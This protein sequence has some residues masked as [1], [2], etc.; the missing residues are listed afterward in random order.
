M[1]LEVGRIIEVRYAGARVCL[2]DGSR[3]CLG[4]RTCK[5]IRSPIAGNIVESVTGDPFPFKGLTRKDM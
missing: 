3:L 4:A 5:S 1:T 2:S